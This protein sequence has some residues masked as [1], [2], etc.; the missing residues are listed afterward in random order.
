MLGERYTVHINLSGICLCKDFLSPRLCDVTMTSHLKE[1]CIPW[2]ESTN[3]NGIRTGFGITNHEWSIYYYFFFIFFFFCNNV[4]AH[5][6]VP[7]SY[8]AIYLDCHKT[9][10]V[11]PRTKLFSELQ[12]H[13]TEPGFQSST[14]RQWKWRHMTS[15]AI[16][17]LM[18]DNSQTIQNCV[19]EHNVLMTITNFNRT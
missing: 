8:D 7:A 5:W 16:F 13:G 10:D 4:S 3:M 11:I 9:F 15:K 12:P 6:D 17:C 14:T 2:S 1:S 18:C 19:P